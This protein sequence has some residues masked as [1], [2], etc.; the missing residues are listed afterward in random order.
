M[1][2]AING[3]AANT[4]FIVLKCDPGS[5]HNRGEQYGINFLLQLQEGNVPEL[6]WLFQEVISWQCLDCSKR[7]F[8]D[9]VL[10][11]LR[12]G[13]PDSALSVL[14]GNIP[15]TD[16]DFFVLRDNVHHSVLIVLGGNVP[17]MSWLF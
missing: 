14:R 11:V 12:G 7:Q 8:P 3:K 13:V 2:C 5:N 17:T 4:S 1:L 16:S 10:I 6:C 9:S 15:D